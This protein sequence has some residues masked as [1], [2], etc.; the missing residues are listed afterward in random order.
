MPLGIDEQSRDGIS[1]KEEQDSRVP[2]QGSDS[3]P[4]EVEK[5]SEIDIDVEMGASTTS[6]QPTSVPASRLQRHVMRQ[7]RAFSSA[8]RVACLPRMMCQRRWRNRQLK[9]NRGLKAA[10]RRRDATTHHFQGS[11]NVK[12]KSLSSCTRRRKMKGPRWT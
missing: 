7:T 8:A 9:K 3:K 11:I 4:G 10:R 6:C 5:K 1:R 2:A 12:F